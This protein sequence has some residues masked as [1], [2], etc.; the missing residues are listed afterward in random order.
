MDPLAVA[1]LRPDILD[2]LN[3]TEKDTWNKV[4]RKLAMATT[5]RLRKEGEKYFDSTSG[6]RKAQSY[7]ELEKG[8][9]KITSDQSALIDEVLGKYFGQEFGNELSEDEEKL[10]RKV[11]GLGI[12]RAQNLSKTKLPF[13]FIINDAP[14]VAWEKTGEGGG[15]LGDENLFRILLSDQGHLV[16]AYNEW[17]S[18]IE[19]PADGKFAEHCIKSVEEEK[20]VNGRPSSQRNIEPLV[21]T[22][23]KLASTNTSS[24]WIGGLQKILRRPTSEMT[25][26]WY[27]SH[28]SY[29]EEERGIF[30]EMLAQNGAL[31]SDKSKGESQADRV[32]HETRADVPAN[33]R[34]FARMIILLLGPVAGMEFLKLILPG[35]ISK[36]L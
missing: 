28:I 13:T 15:G 36:N 18:A 6:E 21:K 26:Y 23:L 14:H 4:I 24:L 7:A 25:R 16:N 33:I 30:I 20:L 8:A 27:D 11:I 22:W 29:D 10:L 5:V 3:P 9:R 1:S 35:D 12:A 32:K 31:S 19:N 17:N 2:S 34:K